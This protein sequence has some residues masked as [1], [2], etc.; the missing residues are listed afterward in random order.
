MQNRSGIL[1]EMSHEGVVAEKAA[2]KVSGPKTTIIIPASSLK[3]GGLVLAL[4][5]GVTFFPVF[6][7]TTD[8]AGVSNTPLA[9]QLT[10]LDSRIAPKI[11]IGANGKFGW[12][13]SSRTE[14]YGTYGVK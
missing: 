9:I 3:S 2:R 6:S 7:L 12:T 5:V 13:G 8:S 11:S 4:T 14:R 1:S 10:T